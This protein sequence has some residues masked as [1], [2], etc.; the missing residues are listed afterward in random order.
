MECAVTALLLRAGMMAS[1]L[2]IVVKNVDIGAYGLVSQ[3]A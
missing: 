3:V 1:R 2:R